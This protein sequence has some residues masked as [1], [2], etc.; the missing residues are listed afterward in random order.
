M[1]ETEPL[2]F[3]TRLSSSS[4]QIPLRNMWKE[5]RHVQ[6]GVYPNR[7]TCRKEP[8]PLL[9]TKPVLGETQGQEGFPCPSKPVGTP[10]GGEGTLDQESGNPIL[11]PTLSPV[12]C[13]SLGKP[14][15]LSGPPS[16][17][18][19]KEII[20]ISKGCSNTFFFFNF[21]LMSLL[22]YVCM[23]VNSFFMFQLLFGGVKPIVSLYQ[24]FYFS[25]HFHINDLLL[26]ELLC[27]LLD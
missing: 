19:N 24:T 7:H 9:L 2:S 12:C 20:L 3:K 18:Q 16:W 23:C 13:E 11:A 1:G 21:P 27:R 4:Q 6:R 25:K 22:S 8:G 17:L 14:L 5:L 15:T 10:S 26:P